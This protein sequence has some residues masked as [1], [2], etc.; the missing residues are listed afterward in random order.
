M[1]ETH[2]IEAGDLIADWV[3]WGPV[4]SQVCCVVPTPAGANLFRQRGERGFQDSIA[5]WLRHQTISAELRVM[6]A[7]PAVGEPPG[8]RPRRPGL[9]VLKQ[10]RDAVTAEMLVPFDLAIF[11]GHFPWVPIVPGAVLVGWAA[12]LAATHGLWPHGVVAAT[13]LKFRRIVQPGPAY[14]LHVERNAAGDRLAFRIESA[15]VPH[16][17]GALAAPA[18]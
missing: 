5:A 4:G 13:A 9:R 15:G 17:Y 1:P 14:H 7:A 6:A 11:A 8:S 16:A 12:E 10:T 2:G 18:S 3:L